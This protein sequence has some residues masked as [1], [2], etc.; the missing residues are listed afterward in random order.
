MKIVGRLSNRVASSKQRFLL[1]SIQ[2]TLKM[3][4]KHLF[5]SFFKI[6]EYTRNGLRFTTGVYTHCDTGPGVFGD[7]TRAC[8]G[9]RTRRAPCGISRA[10]FRRT[11]S[12]RPRCKCRSS[13]A[14]SWAVSRPAESTVWRCRKR[15]APPE[16]DRTGLP[17]AAVA[18]D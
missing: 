4:E 12:R 9:T 8:R 6:L 10:A 11:W 5:C 13:R 17:R 18:L 1:T 7:C 15:A 2:N 14:G 3:S 16:E